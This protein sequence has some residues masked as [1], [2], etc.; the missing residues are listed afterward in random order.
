M[1]SQASRS[2][3]LRWGSNRIWYTTMEGWYS[4]GLITG[5]GRALRC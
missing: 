3:R 4:N 2:G 1:R 5:V